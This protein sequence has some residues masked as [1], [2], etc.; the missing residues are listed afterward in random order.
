MKK[1]ACL[2]IILSI[3]NVESSYSQSIKPW[4]IW[5][6][7]SWGFFI[8]DPQPRSNRPRTPIF[9]ES[10]A[11]KSSSKL[12]S[13]GITL[14]FN[15][16]TSHIPTIRWDASAQRAAPGRADKNIPKCSETISRSTI[17]DFWSLATIRFLRRKFRNFD[18]M[19]KLACVFITLSIRN[20]ESSYSQTTKPWHINID[21]SWRFFI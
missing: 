7:Q 4:P 6:D 5:I 14:R 17:F 8:Y 11:V 20:V 3:R 9:Y 15:H 10:P 19:K 21:Q 16:P 13:P 12:P 18:V 1:L 2:F